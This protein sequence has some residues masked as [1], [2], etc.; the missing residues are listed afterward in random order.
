MN[1]DDIISDILIKRYDI[2]RSSVSHI[3]SVINR[4][5]YKTEKSVEDLISEIKMLPKGKEVINNLTT[6]TIEEEYKDAIF[7]KYLPDVL[8]NITSGA[9]VAGKLKYILYPEDVITM[10]NIHKDHKLRYKIDELFSYTEYT[11]EYAFLK[12]RD[13]EG[14]F[15]MPRYKDSI[16]KEIEERESYENF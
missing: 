3:C 14:L 15:N 11:E 4:V 1:P 10:A 8:K 16:E 2:D 7:R 6:D 5:F 13:Y 9:E 12:D